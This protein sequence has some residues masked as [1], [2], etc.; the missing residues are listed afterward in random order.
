MS[1][2]IIKETM[3]N[4]RELMPIRRTAPARDIHDAVE[5]G[6]YRVRPGTVVRIMHT[7]PPHE[8]WSLLIRGHAYS[9]ATE[10]EALAFL[11]GKYTNA[12]DSLTPYMYDLQL[13]GNELPHD[14]RYHSH[15]V[16]Q[17]LNDYKPWCVHYRQNGTHFDTFAELCAYIEG[18]WGRYIGEESTY[19]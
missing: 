18:R 14:A 3:L 17:H 8:M 2:R 15:P 4:L 10:A 9:Y 13:F 5:R 7:P 11:K 12:P 6:L 16:V 19:A 1:E